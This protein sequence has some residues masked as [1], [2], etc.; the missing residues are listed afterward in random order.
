MLMFNRSELPQ[1]APRFAWDI[2]A[3]FALPFA[4]LAMVPERFYPFLHHDSSLYHGCYIDLPA[5]QNLFANDYYSSRLTVTIP[6]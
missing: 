2:L 6:G 3:L 4:L 5:A 1:R